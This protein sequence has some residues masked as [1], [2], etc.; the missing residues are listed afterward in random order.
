MPVTA[1]SNSNPMAYEQPSV[2]YEGGYAEFLDLK[3]DVIAKLTELVPKELTSEH[4]KEYEMSQEFFDAWTPKA[5]EQWMRLCKGRS[6]MW[7]H[8]MTERCVSVMRTAYMAVLRVSALRHFTFHHENRRFVV[9]LL[10]DAIKRLLGKTGPPSVLLSL[11][12]HNFRKVKEDAQSSVFVLRPVFQTEQMLIV[13]EESREERLRMCLMPFETVAKYKEAICFT[14]R[15][16]FIAKVKA[17]LDQEHSAGCVRFG[18]LAY[19]VRE[20][21]RKETLE[22]MKEEAISRC[23]AQRWCHMM[24]ELL[25]DIVDT[26]CDAYVRLNHQQNPGGAQVVLVRTNDGPSKQALGQ[27]LGDEVM[28]FFEENVPPML[29]KQPKSKRAP[30][31][32]MRMLHEVNLEVRSSSMPEVV[33]AYM[34]RYLRLKMKRDVELVL[35]GSRCKRHLFSRLGADLLSTILN[36]Y[37]LLLLRSP[38]RIEF[39]EEAY[40]EECIQ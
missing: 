33:C 20:Y 17:A 19:G 29:R 9:N 34:P 16:R 37:R 14:L 18:G 31:Y 40:V 38:K 26:A 23:S 30:C 35:H 39:C 22:L 6:R 2:H 28:R 5:E 13:E 3:E 24:T 4:C 27:F 11:E 15:D 1:I 10:V 25:V 8:F 36:H 21:L 12:A 7:A 32:L